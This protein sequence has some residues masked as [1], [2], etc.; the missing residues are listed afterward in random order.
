LDGKTT[1]AENKAIA[2]ACKIAGKSEAW[3]TAVDA[4]T[5]TRTV[6]TAQSDARWAKIMAG[7]MEL[8]GMASRLSAYDRIVWELT[9]TM[10]KARAKAANAKFT[11]TEMDN[12]VEQA[13]A[14]TDSADM[15][16]IRTMADR[17]MAEIEE[18]KALTGD[19]VAADLATILPNE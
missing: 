10:L 7:E 16:R 2:K 9:E 5:F 17:R 14:L 18:L 15:T 11:Q 4:E 1:D 19:V 6:A 8:P 13:I 12:L 3:A